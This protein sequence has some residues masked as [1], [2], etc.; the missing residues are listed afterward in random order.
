VKDT[1]D[2][3]GKGFPHAQGLKFPDDTGFSRHAAF[4]LSLN[5]RL[6][7]AWDFALGLGPGIKPR[8]GNLPTDHP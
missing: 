3:T 5:D 6:A 1:A 2:Q 8:A 7:L 4:L